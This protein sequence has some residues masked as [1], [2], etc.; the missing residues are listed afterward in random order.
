VLALQERLTCD[1]ETLV[2]DN[3]VGVVGGVVSG[4]GGVSGGPIIMGP[5]NPPLACGSSPVPPHPGIE[6]IK[7]RMMSQEVILVL[8]FWVINPWVMV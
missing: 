3:P 6:N 8:G 7:A 2:A 5:P 1:E 4:E